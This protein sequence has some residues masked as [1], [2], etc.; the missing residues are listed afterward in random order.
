LIIF[1]AS[2]TTV[3]K[4]QQQNARIN[5]I[6]LLR[7]GWTRDLVY[8]RFALSYRDVEGLLADREL[9]RPDMIGTPPNGPF[10]LH[11]ANRAP[12]LHDN[13]MGRKPNALRPNATESGR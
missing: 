3:Y 5:W 4:V 1:S 11:V 9:A 2:I 13:P 10:P 12:A 7:G 8:L 6:L